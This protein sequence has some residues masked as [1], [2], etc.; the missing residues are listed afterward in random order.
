MKPPR[1]SLNA[2]RAFEVTARLRSFSGAAEELSVTHGAISRQI[3]TLE[4][5]L[6]VVLLSR[7]AHSTEP[8]PEGKQLSD[9]LSQGFKLIQDSVELI[10]PGPITLSCSTSIMMYWLLPR[11]G[12]LHRDLPGL[13]LS[14]NLGYGGIDFARDNISVAIRLDS[15][16]PPKGVEPKPLVMEWIGPV[17]SPEYMRSAKIKVVEDV[18]RARLLAT[19]TRPRAWED[20]AESA[21]L[22]RLTLPIAESFEHFYLQIQA[23]KCGLGLAN[24]P[25]MLVRDELKSGTLVAPLGFVQGQRSLVLWV[26]PHLAA[27]SEMHLLV[28]WLVEEMSREVAN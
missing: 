24:V 3:R 11:L 6:G 25:R 8:T 2:L 1:P 21:G 14:F 7:S 10:K 13:Q 27:R 15:K 26:A 5:S 4:D 23:A 20:W 18:S 12:G 22:S 28:E 17:C 16:E 9:G 19:N